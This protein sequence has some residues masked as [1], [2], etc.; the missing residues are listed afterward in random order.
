MPTTIRTKIVGNHIIKEVFKEDEYG[1]SWTAYTIVPRAW[2]IAEIRKRYEQKR[3][4][5][6][7]HNPEHG[8]TGM[9][10][11]MILPRVNALELAF[12]F[13]R[14]PYYN[15]A[16]SRFTNEPWV[17]KRNKRFIVFQQSGGWDV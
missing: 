6:T 12:D 4:D 13:L 10:G 1:E 9:W 11:R 2:F 7:N 16:G 8:P 17:L 5:V 14:Y 3:R 15:G